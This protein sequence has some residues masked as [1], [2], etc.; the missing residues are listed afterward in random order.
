MMGN[1]A[2]ITIVHLWIRPTVSILYVEWVNDYKPKVD[3]GRLGVAAL[4]FQTMSHYVWN[5]L[6]SL[7]KVKRSW[8]EVM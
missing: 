8:H 7:D 6:I 4:I 3:F 2:M 1:M 5:N